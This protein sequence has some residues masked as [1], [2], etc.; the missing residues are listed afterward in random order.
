MQTHAQEA[1]ANHPE[2][3][4]LSS[5]RASH[6]TH[7]RAE[8]RHQHHR[9]RQNHLSTERGTPRFLSHR[10][11]GQHANV[12]SPVC[13]GHR[14]KGHRCY[15][16]VACEHGWDG[17]ATEV[18][19][20]SMKTPQWMPN[21]KP[22]TRPEINLCDRIHSLSRILFDLDARCFTFFFDKIKR[23]PPGTPGPLPITLLLLPAPAAS[24]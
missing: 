4:R 7:T 15:V 9:L 18:P 20:R 16:Q 8:W 5:W 11:S 19:N 17:R 1:R 2:S 22:P 23:A 24:A 3:T 12:F 10:S 6:D 13:S 21:R 14:L